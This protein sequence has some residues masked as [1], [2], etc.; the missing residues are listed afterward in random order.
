MHFIQHKLVINAHVSDMS[1]LTN[2]F[3]DFLYSAGKNNQDFIQSLVARD[4]ASNLSTHL[5]R[6]AAVIFNRLKND[7]DRFVYIDGQHES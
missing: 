1:F 4:L 7:H 3:A 5:F 2:N 6:R